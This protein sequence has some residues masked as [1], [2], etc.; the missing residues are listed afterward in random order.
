MVSA[1]ITTILAFVI[2][3]AICTGAFPQYGWNYNGGYPG[4]YPLY[5]PPQSNPAP[6]QGYGYPPNY[7]VQN[8]QNRY[9]SN[10]RFSIPSYAYDLGTVRTRKEWKDQPR[11]V[12][13]YK[14]QYGPF[15]LERSPS[16]EMSTGWS[17]TTLSQKVW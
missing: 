5:Y 4:Y 7:G 17:E 15:E 3:S 16:N 10:G 8:N 14:Q 12:K 6:S 1:K 11:S 13:G 2:A 9:S